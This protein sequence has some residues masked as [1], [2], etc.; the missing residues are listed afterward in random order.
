M[1]SIK[2]ELGMIARADVA[3]IELELQSM[4][5]NLDVIR[6]NLEEIQASSIPVRDDLAAPRVGQRD[7]VSERLRLAMLLAQKRLELFKARVSTGMAT[8]SDELKAQIEVLSAQGEIALLTQR[9]QS[10]G[11]G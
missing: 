3:A 5:T 6:L 7:F 4:Q 11:G 1:A 9:L 8:Q 10:L 2:A